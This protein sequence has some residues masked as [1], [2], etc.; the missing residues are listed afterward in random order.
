MTSY[1][2]A[3]AR[4]LHRYEQ[5]RLDEKVDVAVH[6]VNGALSTWVEPATLIASVF[7]KWSKEDFDSGTSM[8]IEQPTY[9]QVPACV[10][11]V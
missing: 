4:L 8:L 9:V 1:T 6:D 2:H 11:L 3:D 10:T 5:L 7:A